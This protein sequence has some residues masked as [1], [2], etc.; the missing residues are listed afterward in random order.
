MLIYVDHSVAEVTLGIICGCLT[1]FPAFIRHIADIQNKIMEKYRSRSISTIRPWRP[2]TT[3]PI[4]KSLI[5]PGSSAVLSLSLRDASVYSSGKFVSP[6]TAL[7]E[8]G[9]KRRRDQ[10]EE[11]DELEY[12]A[13][14][15]ERCVMQEPSIVRPQR[16]PPVFKQENLERCAA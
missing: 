4:P 7:S 13:G 6:M 9:K 3:N 5:L 8:N 1:A 2:S 11:L 12:V 14:D 16:P 10:W 15:D